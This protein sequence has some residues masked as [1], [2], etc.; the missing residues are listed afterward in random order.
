M[1]NKTVSNKICKDKTAI[2]EIPRQMSAVV[3]LFCIFSIGVGPASEMTYIVSSGALNST[4]S[5]TQAYST[6]YSDRKL[7]HFWLHS[8]LHC[9]H[10]FIAMEPFE[11]FSLYCLRNLMQWHACLFY[12]PI[13]NG[14]KHPIVLIHARQK[15]RLIGYR[16]M[17]TFVYVTRNVT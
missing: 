16:C 7:V 6:R 15:H 11:A 17:C 8:T 9:L 1:H 14:Q 10:L 4:H 12:R 3:E 2:N 13:P 5:L